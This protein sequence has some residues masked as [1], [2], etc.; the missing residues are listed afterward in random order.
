MDT[1]NYYKTKQA[2][3]LDGEKNLFYSFSK[4]DKP[5]IISKNWGEWP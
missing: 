3:I 2:H 4:S 1:L 5:E